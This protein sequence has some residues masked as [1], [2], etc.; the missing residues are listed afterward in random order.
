[1][2]SLSRQT[3]RAQEIKH[4]SSTVAFEDY[5]IEASEVRNAAMLSRSGMVLATTILNLVSTG[6]AV[7]HW[8][9]RGLVNPPWQRGLSYF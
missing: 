2:A 7:V 5:Q 6:T 8:A 1:V 9:L 3:S 4:D